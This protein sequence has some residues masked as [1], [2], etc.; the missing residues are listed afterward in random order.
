MIKSK[1]RSRND[2][3]PALD[4]SAASSF[5]WKEEKKLAMAM[6]SLEGPAADRLETFPDSDTL[7]WV[8]FKHGLAENLGEEP[9]AVIDKLQLRRNL[10]AR[11]QGSDKDVRS[12]ADNYTK[13]LAKAEAMGNK[14]PAQLQLI[15]DLLRR[16]PEPLG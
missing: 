7:T 3:G 11:R 16:F 1:K 14:I 8:G 12:F 15:D 5:E 6:L 13:S 2:C 4:L 9:Q 10:V